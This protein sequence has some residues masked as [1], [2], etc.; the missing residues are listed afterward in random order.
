MG[1]HDE[2]LK[3]DGLYARLVKIDSDPAELSGDAEVKATPAR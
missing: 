3:S 2:L 1:T